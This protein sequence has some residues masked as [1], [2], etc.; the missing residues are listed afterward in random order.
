M[1]DEQQ[2]LRNAGLK[3]TAPRMM[4]LHILDQSKEPHMSAEDIYRIL[5]EQGRDVGIA[6]VYRVLAQ[7]EGAG[8]VKRHN[9]DTGPALYEIERGDH[10]D[11]M[12]CMET[13]NVIE[14]QNEEIEQ[15]QNRVA[16]EA[17]YELV[18]HT[19]ILY[20]KPKKDA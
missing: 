18:G 4:V 20:V 2:E 9:F 13:G 3:V 1:T 15:I 11:H 6:T 17:G 5:L 12:V 16:E 19:L 8:L 10:H 14:F 7:F